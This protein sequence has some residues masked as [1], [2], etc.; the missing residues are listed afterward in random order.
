[1]CVYVCVSWQERAVGQHRKN[2]NTRLQCDSLQQWREQTTP[3][4]ELS[5]RSPASLCQARGPL[6]A[7][8][9]SP[10]MLRCPCTRLD[11]FRR[12]CTVS[13]GLQHRKVTCW[14]GLSWSLSPY[15]DIHENACQTPSNTHGLQDKE[16]NNHS[17]MKGY[18]EKARRC[19]LTHAQWQA[20]FSVMPRSMPEVL[21]QF[22]CHEDSAAQSSSAS[23]FTPR[24]M[25]QQV[26]R[27][28]RGT[29]NYWALATQHTLCKTESPWLLFHFGNQDVE[30]VGLSSF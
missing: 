30:E 8:P 9:L 12:D 1:M 13:S 18:L 27:K 16:K 24:K 23:A 22:L 3:I 6:P 15:C 17:T 19:Q 7:R 11:F 26:R 2:K 28:K 10:L 21:G 25:I 4:P 5:L 20:F 14:V 29:G